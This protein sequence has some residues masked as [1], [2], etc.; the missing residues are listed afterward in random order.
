MNVGKSNPPNKTP[1]KKQYI[2]NLFIALMLA[3]AGAFI[4]YLYEI[5][6]G[7]GGFVISLLSY[8]LL[9]VLIFGY[10]FLKSARHTEKDVRFRPLTPMVSIISIAIY[11]SI[12]FGIS[13]ISDEYL[14]ENPYSIFV[15]TLLVAATLG[16][17][18]KRIQLKGLKLSNGEDIDKLVFQ[19]AISNSFIKLLYSAFPNDGSDAGYSKRH[20]PFIIA[21]LAEQKENYRFLTQMFFYSL[22][23]FAVI[24]TFLVAFYGFVLLDDE[25]FGAGKY[26]KQINRNIGEIKILN[27]ERE[28]LAYR[29]TEFSKS[30]VVA[31]LEQLKNASELNSLGER[32]E[33]Y[34]KDTSHFEIDELAFG[35]AKLLR[36]QIEIEI[37]YSYTDCSITSF[38]ND[39]N[40]YM[41]ARDATKNLEKTTKNKN[42]IS[43]ASKISK[44][45]SSKNK[46]F[47]EIKR[48]FYKI[49][50]NE[51]NLIESINNI[52]ETIKRESANDEG[53][54]YN[55]IKRLSIGFF[56][57]T[58]FWHCLDIWPINIR[59][60]C[61]N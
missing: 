40:K 19:A 49:K 11:L 51:N 16:A 52:A 18:T 6:I 33:N 36:S 21:S 44:S 2:F 15:D 14:K 35:N 47:E 56:V 7:A 25:S 38:E 31:I 55:F 61:Q 28:T 58:F 59:P 57:G 60:T 4:S 5:N 39:F 23:F 22:V 43:V 45:F 1:L 54:Y 48:E 30:Q 42:I 26:A 29:F 8:N 53:R 24:F 37:P 46:E 13:S 10:L 20:M 9:L 17:I 34:V 12:P 50:E 3:S 41:E 32:L 27:K